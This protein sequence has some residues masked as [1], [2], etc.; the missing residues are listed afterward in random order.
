MSISITSCNIPNNRTKSIS[1]IGSYRLRRFNGDG[2]LNEVAAFYPLIS[3]QLAEALVN[4]GEQVTPDAVRALTSFHFPVRPSLLRRRHP[5]CMETSTSTDG[6]LVLGGC[7]RCLFR[8]ICLHFASTVRSR[9]GYSS[10]VPLHA[11]PC[12]NN[13]GRSSVVRSFSLDHLEKYNFML[14]ERECVRVCTIN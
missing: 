11:L 12:V 3:R 5:L 10:G 1:E 14:F 8:P 9:Y 2:L 7:F 6:V 13:S 4:I